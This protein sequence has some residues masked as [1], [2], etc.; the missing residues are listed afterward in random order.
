MT[1]LPN[2]ETNDALAQIEAAVA[3]SASPDARKERMPLVWIAATLGVGLA[4]AALY[5]GGRILTARSHDPAPVKMSVPVQPAQAT[6]VQASV[7]QPQLEPAPQAAQP[8]EPKPAEPK[9]AADD[10]LPMIVPQPGER[11]IQVSA[12]NQEAA[13]RY[14][15]QLRL[16]N[17]KPLVAPGPRP[18][19]LRVLLGPFFDQDAL[20]ETKNDLERAGIKNFVRRY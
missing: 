10:Q 13:L 2:N 20:A 17:L 3:L 15:T 6:A 11:Y 7:Q 16:A 5:L 19:L 18:E 1:I 8:A 9:P 4:I 12:L 14:V